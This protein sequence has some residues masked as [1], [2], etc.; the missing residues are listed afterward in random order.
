MYLEGGELTLIDDIYIV[1]ATGIYEKYT[2]G[3]MVW[4]DLQYDPSY[5]SEVTMTE[6]APNNIR[7]DE[8]NA[9]MLDDE[10]TIRITSEGGHYQAIYGNSTGEQIG[11]VF[12]NP[13]V[14][15]DSN[16]TKV[17]VGTN[18]GY[19]FLFPKGAYHV[20]ADRVEHVLGNRKF[21]MEDGALM[22]VI[23]EVLVHATGMYTKFIGGEFIEDI[24]SADPIYVAEIT[25]PMPTKE[26]SANQRDP[27]LHED[28]H[29]HHFTITR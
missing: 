3:T 4:N 29:G 5:I 2:G 12:Q 18:Q 8:N 15:T 19:S 28:E 22:L 24:I 9:G 14:M 20:P 1:S 6:P 17:R 11:Q 7:K 16:D 25:L 10:I 27:D 23:N 26:D 21:I 13:V